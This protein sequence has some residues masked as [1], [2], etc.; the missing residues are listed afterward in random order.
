M[1]RKCLT[2]IIIRHVGLKSKGTS[3]EWGM[4]LVKTREGLYLAPSKNNFEN[5]ASATTLQHYMMIRAKWELN[6]QLTIIILSKKKKLRTSYYLKN[7]SFF[8]TQST[9]QNTIQG[10][11]NCII[12]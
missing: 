2:L 10:F 7:A 8:R 9:I 5:V 12:F 11:L 4:L 3:N 1:I 6:W